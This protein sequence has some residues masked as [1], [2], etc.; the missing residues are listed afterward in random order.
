M[1]LLPGRHDTAA[2]FE[3]HGFVQAARGFG[4][5]VD[6]VAVDA[7]YGYYIG[8]TLGQ[9]L[10]E[11]VFAPARIRGYRA[12]WLSGI[13]MGGLGAL[14]YAEQHPNEVEG[15]LVIAPFLGDDDLINEIE[16]AG[17]LAKWK[18]TAQP[19]PDDYLRQLWLWLGRCIPQAQGC[20]RIFLGFG[21]S[22]RFA[23]AERLLAAALPSDQVVE[24]PGEH[25]WGPWHQIFSLSL[26][27]M[28]PASAP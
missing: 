2:D 4:A 5:P 25:D 23:R 27:R 17:G 20:P 6:L 1:V 3:K 16:R 11:D 26:A 10:A 9:R 8:R 19:S 21:G 7:R 22:D 14:I 13:S 15:L 28:F 12:F 24:V 18:T